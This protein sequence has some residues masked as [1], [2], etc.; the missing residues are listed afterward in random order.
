MK[1]TMF[2]KLKLH[3]ETVRLLEEPVLAGVAAGVSRTYVCC[4]AT[5][6]CSGCLPCA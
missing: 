5:H 3:R 2:G 4:T 1:K 6:G